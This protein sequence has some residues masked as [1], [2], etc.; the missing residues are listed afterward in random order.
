[1]GNKQTLLA[2]TFGWGKTCR[3]YRD[4]IEIAGKSY[5]LDDLTYIHPTYRTLFGVASARLELCF[6]LRRLI[7]RGIADQ[8]A[9]RQMVS[10]M[11]PFAEHIGPD[12]LAHRLRSR[13]A[14]SRELA[15]IQAKTWERTQKIPALANESCPCAS[16]ISAPPAVP[17]SEQ[18]EMPSPVEPVLAAEPTDAF[19]DFL[20]LAEQPTSHI[21]ATLLPSSERPSVEV[22][23]QD[24]AGPQSEQPSD[25][26]DDLP[27]EEARSETVV[28]A[29]GIAA[30]P[31]TDGMVG[32]FFSTRPTTP[33]PLPT[34]GKPPQAG[35]NRE[36]SSAPVPAKVTL[37]GSMA[38]VLRAAEQRPRPLYKKPSARLSRF[39]PPLRPMQLVNPLLSLEQPLVRA[40]DGHV[41]RKK[42][43]L[44]LD[45]A[46]QNTAR[47]QKEMQGVSKKVS[48]VRRASVQVQEPSVL[49]IIHVP[50]RL[51]AGECA[52]YSIG[53]ALCSDRLVGSA[54][55]SSPPLDRGLLILTNRRIFYLGK[56][57]QLI[58][59]YTHLWS[60]SLLHTAVALHIEG[61]VRRILLDVEHPEEWAGRIEL[62]ARIA[63]RSPQPA[64][65]FVLPGVRPASILPITVKRA[66]LTLAN[67][68]VNAIP[69]SVRKA[70]EFATIEL[71]P[72][73]DRSIVETTTVEFAPETN[74]GMVEATTVVF[75]RRASQ[76]VVEAT[77]ITFDVHAVQNIVEAATIDL[78]SERPRDVSDAP[79]MHLQLRNERCIEEMETREFVLPSEQKTLEIAMHSSERECQDYPPRPGSSS[80]LEESDTQILSPGEGGEGVIQTP[81]VRGKPSIVDEDEEQTDVVAVARAGDAILRKIDDSLARALPGRNDGMDEED[82][83]VPMRRRRG[84]PPGTYSLRPGMERSVSESAR[85][86]RNAVRSRLLSRTRYLQERRENA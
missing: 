41:A 72:R 21:S 52:H 61:Q 59:A 85:I 10:H 27:A 64:P 37:S 80:A 57:C 14:R 83:T 76:N 78:S 86:K 53:A 65:M 29:P 74:Q 36:I 50:V 22:V 46:A 25:A 12:T 6:G 77:T 35:E 32:A 39:E 51:Q 33:M 18:G 54:R 26:K 66:A 34:T 11:Q 45:Q 8:D 70:S 1:M 62:L 81:V 15:R 20:D 31:P 28:E 17:A 60:V 55:V 3:L 82:R 48:T 84:V 67:R 5:S 13:S 43:L 44:P 75:G 69:A 71:P 40:F 58:L 73:V 79:T 23:T 56:R 47:P 9:A 63:R 7:L 4:S 2:C 68:Q 30:E 42:P 19:D 38:A 49:P 16:E 24:D